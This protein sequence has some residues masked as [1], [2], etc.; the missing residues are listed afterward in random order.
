MLA[1]IDNWG[2]WPWGTFSQQHD[3]L[4]MLGVKISIM[5]FQILSVYNCIQSFGLRSYRLFYLFQWL[6]R[7]M[8]SWFLVTSSNFVCGTHDDRVRRVCRGRANTSH[9]ALTTCTMVWGVYAMTVDH[10][11]SSLVL[12][13]QGNLNAVR[14]VANILQPVTISYHQGLTNLFSITRVHI[15]QG[16]LWTI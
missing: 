4:E 12:T 6:G 15:R 11:W 1:K 3:S 9:T 8:H 5:I 14:Y 13:V 2:Y 7:M 16:L 10:L